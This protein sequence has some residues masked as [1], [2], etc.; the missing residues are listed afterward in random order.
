MRTENPIPSA[1]DAFSAKGFEDY[2]ID[3]MFFKRPTVNATRAKRDLLDFSEVATVHG[4]TSSQVSGK[5]EPRVVI[6]QTI[7][8]NDSSIKQW[9]ATFNNLTHYTTYGITIRA[10]LT[11]RTGRSY[12]SDPPAE[13]RHRTKPISECSP[14]APSASLYSS[15][16]SLSLSPQV[17]MIRCSMLLSL[18]NRPTLPD[19]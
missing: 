8:I 17:I 9:S 7:L 12:C 1:E 15:L 18:L 5:K 14:L 2:L 4:N 19:Q 13:I 10:C 11:P 3:E 16:L 6:S